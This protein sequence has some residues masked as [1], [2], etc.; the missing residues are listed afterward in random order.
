MIIDAEKAI[1]GRV[2]TTAA[3]QA[4]LGE[5]VHIVNCEK[6]I[7]IGAPKKIA[8]RGREKR[9]L[10]QPNQGPYIQT[11]PFRY[12]RRIVRGMLPYDKPRGKTAY[13][14]V[15]CYESV[16][17]QF[18]DKKLI[19]IKHAGGDTLPTRKHITIEKLCKEIK[20]R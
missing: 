3:K 17:S 1:I 14:K 16:P 11:Q 7:I 10:G 5:E 2:A 19:K 4:L 8:E 12:V 9:R 15:K 18:K 6:A 20:E 13:E